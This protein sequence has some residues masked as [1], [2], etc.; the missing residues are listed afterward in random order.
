MKTTILS[1]ILISLLFF[2]SLSSAGVTVDKTTVNITAGDSFVL[3]YNVTDSSSNCFVSVEI[4]PD[5]EGF[6]LSYVDSFKLPST[7]VL[8]VNTSMLLVPGTY[9][10]T[11]TFS[12]DSPS[13]PKVSRHTHYSAQ[14][15]TPVPAIPVN[16]TPPSEPEPDKNDTL[17]PG[18]EPVK[19]EFPCLYVFI[20][21]I[22]L[23]SVLL[24]IIVRKK[25]KG[26]VK[27]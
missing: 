15:E 25:L 13:S 21:V 26:N 9:Y 5:S 18:N 14:P 11:T 24:L 19:S 2:V 4:T 7:F 16:E 1:L 17:L 10:I 23:V 6:L 27:K 20:I 3:V 8:R 12:T 22:I